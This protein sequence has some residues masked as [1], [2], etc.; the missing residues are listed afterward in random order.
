M[1]LKLKTTTIPEFLVSIIPNGAAAPCFSSSV[2]IKCS[3]VE[4]ELCSVRLLKKLL[5]LLQPLLLNV[6]RKFIYFK[7]TTTTT[8]A[9]AADFYVISC[10]FINIF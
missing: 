3:A 5:L 6:A 4:G 8:A 1:L 9:A 7:F 10:V 2:R